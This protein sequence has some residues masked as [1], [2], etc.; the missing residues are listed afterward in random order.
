MVFTD[1][2]EIHL[3]L[4]QRYYFLLILWSI[5][6]FWICQWKLIWDFEINGDMILY[7]KYIFVISIWNALVGIQGIE[8]V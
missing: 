8:R 4:E 3:Y 2:C 6:I 1:T 7:I 5:L